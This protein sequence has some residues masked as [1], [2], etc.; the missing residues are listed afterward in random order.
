MTQIW[1]TICTHPNCLWL[2]PYVWWWNPYVWCLMDLNCHILRCSLISTDIPLYLNDIYKDKP[3]ILK[4][5]PMSH[6]SYSWLLLGYP[7]QNCRA[8]PHP[9]RWTR[10]RLRR[11]R[12]WYPRHCCRTRPRS[13]DLCCCRRPTPE[14]RLRRRCGKL[15]LGLPSGYPLVK[16][17]QLWNFME[18]LYF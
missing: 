17:K 18:H 3:A 11:G 4:D 14:A 5:I 12:C 6:N 8:T 7:Q 15:R 13:R 9:D 1:P 16:Y 2:N 10:P